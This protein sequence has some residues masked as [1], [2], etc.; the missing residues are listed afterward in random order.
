MTSDAN[1][2]SAASPVIFAVT[3]MAILALELG[4]ESNPTFTM[5]AQNDLPDASPRGPKRAYVESGFSVRHPSVHAACGKPQRQ[6]GKC[7]QTPYVDKNYKRS[8]G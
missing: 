3:A 8:L 5:L 6:Q 2:N 4:I 7:R 1:F